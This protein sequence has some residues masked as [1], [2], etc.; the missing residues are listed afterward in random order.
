M[1]GV[2]FKFCL[3]FDSV[4]LTALVRSS[5]E[6]A[7]PGMVSPAAPTVLLQ[8]LCHFKIVF[9][10][11]APCQLTRGCVGPTGHSLYRHCCQTAAA[12]CLT[13]VPTCL[14][15]GVFLL[16]ELLGLQEPSPVGPAKLGILLITWTVADRLGT[17]CAAEAV[18]PM[19]HCHRPNRRV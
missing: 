13:E 5:E 14:A 7:A 4:G 16:S 6:R 8:V 18:S 15:D 12:S 19:Y 17:A 10:A 1:V 11:V 9:T 2:G 3:V